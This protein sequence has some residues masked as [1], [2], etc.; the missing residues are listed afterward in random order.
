VIPLVTTVV[1]FVVKTLSRPQPLPAW[2]KKPELLVEMTEPVTLNDEAADDGVALAPDDGEPTG[3]GV[4]TDVVTGTLGKDADV[5]ADGSA[6]DPV[7]PPQAES[8]ASME[9]ATT[10]RRSIGTDDTRK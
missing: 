6:W 8:V 2:I 5:P 9:S 4:A 7:P 3:T 1:A 10:L